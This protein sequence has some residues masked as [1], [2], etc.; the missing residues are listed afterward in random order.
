MK[1]LMSTMALAGL[2]AL[3]AG[4]TSAAVNVT[5][6]HPENFHDLPFP[7]WERKEMLDQIADHFKKL[8]E[9]LPPGQDLRIEIT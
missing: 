6:I 1:S 7:G 4:S 8:G 9:N 2:L 5:W 3:A